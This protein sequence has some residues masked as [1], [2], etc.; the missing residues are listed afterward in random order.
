MKHL[1][2]YAEFECCQESIIS[3]REGP[4]HFEIPGNHTTKEQARQEYQKYE[5]QLKKH[6]KDEYPKYK[7]NNIL[8]QNELNKTITRLRLSGSNQ[9][10]SITLKDLL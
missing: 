3:E 9:P 10:T 2:F 7:F 8:N 1:K 4:W 6:C 5:D